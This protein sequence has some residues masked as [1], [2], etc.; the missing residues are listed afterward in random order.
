MSKSNQTQ[1]TP[2]APQS[3]AYYRGKEAI[4]RKSAFGCG[5][6]GYN[7][8]WMVVSSYLMFFMTDV[9]LVPATAVSLSLI[10]ISEPTRLGRSRMP[11]SA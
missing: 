8:I 2:V 11:S 10:H 4:W 7:L 3:T 5:T 1:G 6:V 9:A